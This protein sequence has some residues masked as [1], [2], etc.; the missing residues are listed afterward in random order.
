M[1]LLLDTHLLLWA[2]EDDPKLPGEARLLILDPTNEVFVSAIALW[3][4][5]IKRHLGKLRADP[6]MVFQAIPTSGFQ[7]LAFSP[8]HAVAVSDL[9]SLHRDPFDRAMVAQASCEPLILL[10]HDRQVANY[11]DMVRLV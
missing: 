8:E 4:I 11:G 10:T 6:V 7:P 1:Q 2:L 5:V 9:P 3:E